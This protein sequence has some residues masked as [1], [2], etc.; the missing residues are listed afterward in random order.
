MLRSVEFR[1]RSGGRA[2]ARR[3][4]R[5]NVHAFVIGDLVL[6]EGTQLDALWETLNGGVRH[7]VVEYSPYW[8][9]PHFMT[10]RED[11]RRVVTHADLVLLLPDGGCLAWDARREEP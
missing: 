9:V 6:D 5:K 10:S 4:Q 7:E 8:N 11:G 3:E 2:R 1:V